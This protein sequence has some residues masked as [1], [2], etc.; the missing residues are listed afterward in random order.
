[1]AELVPWAG[2][3]L[4]QAAEVLAVQLTRAVRATLEFPPWLLKTREAGLT[5]IV[6][7]FGDWATVTDC[8]DTP[9]AVSAMLPVRGVR[10]RF[11]STVT[12]I[13]PLL[14]PEP[15]ETLSQSRVSPTVQLVLEVTLNDR[16]PAPDSNCSE[17]G[18]ALRKGGAAFWVTVTEVLGSPWPVTEMDA[19]RGL[20]RALAETDTVTVPL[21]EPE[22]GE[23][24]SQVEDSLTVQDVL[25]VM[26]KLSVPP[27]S[28]A[29]REGVETLKAGAAPLCT[30]DTVWVL[31]SEPVKVRVALRAKIEGLAWQVKVSAAFP[32]PVL[33][34]ALSQEGSPER[35]QATLAVTF[36]D[37]VPPVLPKLSDVGDRVMLGSRPAW[38]MVT[39]T[40]AAPVALSVRVAVLGL[41]L[42]LGE[43]VT[44][45]A[46]LPEPLGEDSVTQLWEAVA[47]QAVL[48]LTCTVADPPD[49]PSDRVEGEADKVA[50][51]PLCVMDTVLEGTPAPDT[52]IVAVRPVFKGLGVAVTA[53]LALPE[54]E[55]VLTLSQ[56]AISVTV[57]LTPD[58]VMAND[59]LPPAA[60]NY[61]ELGLT[62]RLLPLV[63]VTV[64]GLLWVSLPARM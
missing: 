20:A 50:D 10:A 17:A 60:L 33:G 51:T 5:E 58:E 8:G 24:L 46:A 37:V 38:V 63:T 28:L 43:A 13:W 57:Q 21:L 56:S 31:A 64:M 2:A 14:V 29:V 15:W 3:T 47:V 9:G 23:I 1:M 53:M 7:V 32:L 59:E 16:V 11:S 36:R 55:G 35:V 22:A 61:R 52:V 30:T 40:D 4:S 25:E 27:V 54:P 62:L 6:F 18:L 41:V 42:G 44:E 26:E 34:V 45:R 19:V 12:C 48:E 39:L 49:P